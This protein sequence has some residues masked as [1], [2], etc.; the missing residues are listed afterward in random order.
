MRAT[1]ALPLAIA[2]RSN[3]RATSA[4]QIVGHKR[5]ILFAPLLHFQ[6]LLGG[7]AC[8]GVSDRTVQHPVENVKR[9]PLQAEAVG[10][11][12]VVHAA[13]QNVVLGDHFDNV[14]AVLHTLQAMRQRA[15]V[16][17]RFGDGLVGLRFERLGQL[18]EQRR[19][20]IVQ[21]R[22]VEVAG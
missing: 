21:G 16:A 20:V 2:L 8:H 1:S 19:Q 22:N 14:K 13:A 12:E 18:F 6:R 17:Q 4:A 15:A 9:P 7:E 3:T 5:E 11:G 10:L